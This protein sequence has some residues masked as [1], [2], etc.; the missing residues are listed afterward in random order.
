[1]KLQVLKMGNK[2]GIY[3]PKSHSKNIKDRLVEL[4]VKNN[5]HE[6]T[7]LVLYNSTICLRK[8]LVKALDIQ[9]GDVIEI[10]MNEVADI[11]R[12]NKIFSNGKIDL[13][14]LIPKT[15]GQGNQ[16]FVINYFLKNEEWL[17]IWYCHNR[18]SGKQIELK[19]Y[20]DIDTYGRLLGQ[21][22]AEGTKNKNRFILEFVNKSLSEHKDFINYLGLI[23]IKKESI[24]TCLMILSRG[25]DIQKAKKEFEDAIGIPIYCVT[26]HK[27]SKGSYA[28][29]TFIRS[30]LL[31]EIIMHSLDR[32]RKNLVE[33]EWCNNYKAFANAFFAKLLTG[34]GTLDIQENNRQYNFPEAR[35]SITDCNI[36]YLN[37]YAAI[38][39]K[40]GYLSK[41]L[42]KHIRV[43]SYA[44]FFKLIH[45]YHIKAFK[46]TQNWKKLL[47]LIETNLKGRRLK[48]YLRFSDL[49]NHDSFTSKDIVDMY[50]VGS[51]AA[52]NWL[53]NKEKEGYIKKINDKGLIRWTLTPKAIKLA[54][55]LQSHR[56]EHKAS[57]SV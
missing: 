36:G 18:G 47:V 5:E 9:I 21:Y 15:T 56:D 19:R 57:I 25:T 7:L 23:G 45:L 43:R 34:D 8:E 6:K 51:R 53:C 40:F 33:N 31:T 38:M 3:I 35:I 11:K 20:V 55:I 42:E 46:N 27:N 2:L 14:A 1:M 24:Y 50:S 41:I 49:I 44:G 22:Q 26:K 37:D 32:L 10:T 17:R 39:E 48:T 28:Y 54:K 16:I 30:K 4:A 12:H 52:C 29:K 13:L